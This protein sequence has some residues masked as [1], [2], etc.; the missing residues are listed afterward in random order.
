MSPTPPP[1]RSAR[2]PSPAG[3]ERIRPG[4]EGVVVAETVLSH[5]DSERGMLWVRVRPIPEHVERYGYEGTVAL[6]WEG[7]AGRNLTRD[8]MTKVLGV[9]R[10]QA[11]DRIDSWLPVAAGRPLDDAIRIG[12]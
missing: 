7:F 2:S 12:L 5:S 9:A 4:L 8:L 10:R 3:A 6:L 1:P 11:F